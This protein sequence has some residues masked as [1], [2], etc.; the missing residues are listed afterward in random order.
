MGPETG[1]SPEEMGAD[2]EGRIKNQELAYEMAKAEIEPREKLA[3]ALELGLSK[4]S[5]EELGLEVDK[6]SERR[7][8]EYE[9]AMQEADRTLTELLKNPTGEVK[10]DLIHR[11]RID[12][13][14]ESIS[15][16]T[17]QVRKNDQGEPMEYA[18]GEPMLEYKT[19]HI[20]GKEKYLTSDLETSGNLWR[21]SL[22]FEDKEKFTTIR[23]DE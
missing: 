9:A 19:F 18:S 17:C 14:W 11:D 4:E 20:G 13:V 6:S 8:E 10:T 2:N 23:H 12:D 3:V 7:R 22:K 15:Y 21:L 5:I 16:R 1:P